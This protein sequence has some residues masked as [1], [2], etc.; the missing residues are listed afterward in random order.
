MKQIIIKIV[1][2][3]LFSISNAQDSLSAKQL[4][5][6]TYAFDIVEGK[7]I[8]EGEVFLKQ[9]MAKAQFTMLGEYHG[10]MRI[11]EFTNAIIPVLNNL[12]YKAMVL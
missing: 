1:A 10:S 7:L 11:S 3:L 12:N 9:E 8:G 6:L 4:K 5:P 2:C